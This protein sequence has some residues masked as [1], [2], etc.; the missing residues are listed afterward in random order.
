MARNAPTQPSFPF[1]A[2][3]F[4][5]WIQKGLK[6]LD[7]GQLEEAAGCFRKALQ[8]KVDAGVFLNLGVICGRLGRIDEAIDHL[9]K[10]VE[11]WPDHTEPV[12]NLGVALAQKGRLEEAAA[13]YEKTLQLDPRC[14]QAYLDLGNLYLSKGKMEDAIFLF[15][16]A[17]RCN[18]KFAP[19]HLALGL[20]LGRQAKLGE[21]IACFEQAIRLKPTLAEAHHHLGIAFMDLNRHEDAAD[22]F[23]MALKYSP[24]S[25]HNLSH[26]GVAL[27]ELSQDQ[28]S[29]DCFQKALQQMPNATDIHNNFGNALRLMGR[30]QDAEAQFR[31]ADQLKPNDPG[32]QNNLGIVHVFAGRVHAALSCYDRAIELAPDY[33]SAH[34]NRAFAWLTLAD[35]ERGWEEYEWRWREKNVTPR[36]FPQ[37]VWDGSPLEGKRILLHAEQGFGD[38]LQFIRYAALVK[39]RG[40]FVIFEGPQPLM[41]LLASVKEIDH[42]VSRGDPLPPFDVHCALLGLPRLFKSDLNT[43]PARVPYLLPEKRR[44]EGWRD[45][46]RSIPGFKVG[47]AWQGSKA[48][49]ADRH[50][51]VPL[52]FFEPLAQIPGVT[53]ISLQ[54]GPGSEQ[55]AQLNN[56]FTVRDLPAQVDQDGAF[57]DT[58]AIMQHLDLI[59]TSDTSM[60][61]LA[62]ALGVPV[63]M[64]ISS[65]AD[66]RWLLER[67]D[68]PWYPTM[69]VF[70]QKQLGDWP[71][72]FSR[73]SE[74]LAEKVGV[75]KV[76]RPAVVIDTEVVA[77]HNEGT[78]LIGQGQREEGIALLRQALARE[79]RWDTHSNLAI[80]LAQL[81]Q[82]DEAIALFQKYLDQHH[83]EP[84]AYNNLGLACLDAGR[85]SEAERNFRQAIRCGPSIPDS[86]NNLA[87]SLLRQ[88]KWDEAAFW[89]QRC[90]QIPSDYLPALTNLIFVLR[91]QGKNAEALQ[92][93]LQVL[94][95]HPDAVQVHIDAGSLLIKEQRL[96]E[97]EVHF[98]R[99]V[100]LQPDNPDALN[101]L[102]FLLSD[103]NRLEEAEACLERCIQMRPDH[104]DAHR[105]LALVKL[106]LGKLQQGWQDYEWRWKVNGQEANPGL[107]PRWD[108]TPLQDRTLLVTPEQGIGDLIHFVRYLPLLKQNGG[109]V[110]FVCPQPL[111]PLLQ[112]SGLPIDEIVP[113]NSPLPPADVTAPLLSL[114]GLCGTTL[115][116]I[117]AEVPYLRAD[118]DLV[119]HWKRRLQQV[120]GFRVG[121][122][123]QGN[124][125]YGGDCY[126]SFPLKHFAALAQVEGV[127]LISLQKG[128]GSE[129]LSR[130]AA[131]V[132]VLDLGRQIDEGKGAF[133]DTAA[134]LTNLDLLVAPD[135]SLIH[136]G[137]THE[138]P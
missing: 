58:A 40:G 33:P 43:L 125:G 37:P 56:R 7:Q 39:Q 138:I 102:G 6:L 122:A 54:K 27:A 19:A 113:Q 28:E 25:P 85:V 24:H 101:N 14:A 15:Q 119:E 31:H 97:A 53:L 80:A 38:T 34:L 17:I 51:S 134:V 84:G 114:P 109:R 120:R 1:T 49:K 52:R 11:L 78:R 47:I 18:E 36:E 106:L 60:P 93:C 16:Q 133:L 87:V 10:A 89:L 95:R 55:I 110:L 23:R 107:P 50:R 124:P 44:V 13:C 128:H 63:W 92:L 121:I 116:T 22:A 100:Q 45:A 57:V 82:F 103:L 136:P 12:R 137:Q 135:T 21:A 81:K 98:Q 62:G 3:E 8:F 88:Q 4:E 26:L 66:W 99:V 94:A 83:H 70:R 118:P 20:C 67:E 5:S 75:K 32:I 73:I 79:H 29:I 111:I 131:E 59:I 129:Q 86:Y 68:N 35:F 96:E 74:A 112:L 108:G 77:L 90:I 65:A 9:R 127:Q 105:N 42:L 30:L 76:Q 48:F 126:R 71:E 2:P 117:P 72:V 46:I 123:W 91:Q 130:F 115:E 41:R 69:R 132:N 104:G 64:A 61:H